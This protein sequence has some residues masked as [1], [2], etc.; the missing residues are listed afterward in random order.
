MKTITPYVVLQYLRR[1]GVFWTLGFLIYYASHSG[2]LTF[3][4]PGYGAW[5]FHAR[6]D[7]SDVRVFHQVM[8]RRAYHLPVKLP[9]ARFIVDAGANAGYASLFFA[10]A[11]PGARILA[12]EPDRSNF[13]TLCA[14]AKEAGRIE[15]FHGAL[16]PVETR[17]SIQNPSAPKTA[18]M[19]GA[20]GNN[21]GD[22]P[23]LTVPGIVARHGFIDILKLDIE[24]AELELFAHP[25]L[26]WLDHVGCLIIELHDFM[27][28]GCSMAFYR[29]IAGRSFQQHISGENLIVVFEPSGKPLPAAS[30]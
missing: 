20:P 9:P 2:L 8:L 30:V 29:A 3:K 16:W 26:S 18:I 4:V 23:T 12:I 5:Q 22:V 1:Y 28:A 14:N 7:S 11:H 25:D 10:Q 17:L 19:V 15:C 6:K 24:G 13:D 21:D 27:R